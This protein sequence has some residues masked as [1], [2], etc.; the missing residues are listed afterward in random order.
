MQLWQKRDDLVLTFL[1]HFVTINLYI[2]ANSPSSLELSDD[3]HLLT[4]IYCR[5]ILTIQH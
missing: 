4:I 3:V 2:V 1:N 5:S